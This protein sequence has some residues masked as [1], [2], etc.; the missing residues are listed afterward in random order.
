MPAFGS[1]VSGAARRRLRSTRPR[2]AEEN[3][4]RSQLACWCRSLA[5]LSDVW[6]LARSDLDIGDGLGARRTEVGR[7]SLV[8]RTCSAPLH[9]DR[10]AKSSRPPASRRFAPA[11]AWHLR[12]RGRRMKPT[13]TGR[14]APWRSSAPDRCR[15]RRCTKSPYWRRCRQPCPSQHRTAK[16]RPRVAADYWHRH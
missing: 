16:A 11:C 4:L 2:S 9:L 3:R 5:A 15:S 8:Q 1:V 14:S 10:W 6:A 13:K 12:W 7:Q